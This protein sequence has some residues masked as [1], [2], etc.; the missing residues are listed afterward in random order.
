MGDYNPRAAV[1]S[2]DG[3]YRAGLA[4]LY[5]QLNL[6]VP[7]ALAQAIS[8]GRGEPEAGGAMRRAIE[9]SPTG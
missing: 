1:A 4:N 6:P 7:A 3:L 8:H 5:R 2:F 9:S